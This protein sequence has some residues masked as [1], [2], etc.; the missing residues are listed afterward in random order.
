MN[1]APTRRD[2]CEEVTSIS[3][4][5]WR[6]SNSTL[7]SMHIDIEDGSGPTAAVPRMFPLLPADLQQKLQSNFRKYDTDHSG[8]LE[9][10]EVVAAVQEEFPLE[11]A[12]NVGALFKVVKCYDE[13]CSDSN[14]TCDTKQH[15]PDH[16]TS[17]G[18]SRVDSPY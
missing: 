13:T 9:A 7:R 8:T 16:N 2:C 3:Q 6:P 1:R 10:V 14:P 15:R 11:N 17:F 5:F 18:H 4:L 12:T